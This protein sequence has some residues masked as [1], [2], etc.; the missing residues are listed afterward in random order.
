M[1]ISANGAVTNLRQ[2]T[3]F[4]FREYRDVYV[5]AKCYK[6]GVISLLQYLGNVSFADVFGVTG[7]E[8]TSF[9][10]ELESVIEELQL[11]D[12]AVGRTEREDDLA[13]RSGVEKCFFD[14][15]VLGRV[16]EPNGTSIN[17]IR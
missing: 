5:C 1:F 11:A 2:M 13:A 3:R 14:H 17:I 10:G 6:I 7:A 12:L 16:G 15:I 4:I 8:L 9:R